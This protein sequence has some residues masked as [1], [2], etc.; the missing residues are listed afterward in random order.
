L[1]QNVDVRLF[2]FRLARTTVRLVSLGVVGAQ[3]LLQHFM[4]IRC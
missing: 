3:A 4:N 1:V 2:F